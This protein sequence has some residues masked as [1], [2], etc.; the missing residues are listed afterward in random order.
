[1]APMLYVY[2]IFLHHIL[3]PHASSPTTAPTLF[4][5]ACSTDGK[6]TRGHHGRILVASREQ[7]VLRLRVQRRLHGPEWRDV[8][9]LPGWHVQGRV[10]SRIVQQLPL[11]YDLETHARTIDCDDADGYL[12]LVRSV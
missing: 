11:G 7:R 5:L 4:E 6:L 12:A 1:M 2:Y 8:H 3:P 9:C 10:G